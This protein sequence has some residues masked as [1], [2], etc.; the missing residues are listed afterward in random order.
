ME[1]EDIKG[2]YLHYISHRND[3]LPTCGSDDACEMINELLNVHTDSKS[4]FM[5][6]R[7][8]EID[9]LHNEEKIFDLYNQMN[10]LRKENDT[11]RALIK[12]FFDG[13]IK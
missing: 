11:Y 1:I 8:R 12:A 10:I 3:D 13:V 4:Y 2:S 5:Y 7:D 9:I 6:K